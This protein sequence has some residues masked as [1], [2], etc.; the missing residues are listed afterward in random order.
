MVQHQKYKTLRR[1]VKTQAQMERGRWAQKY[2][3]NNKNIIKNS[4]QR[5]SIQKGRANEIIIR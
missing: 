5:K 4:A 3:W 2:E 1:R